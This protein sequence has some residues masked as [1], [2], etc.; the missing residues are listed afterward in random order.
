M[1]KEA[2]RQYREHSIYTVIQEVLRLT[3]FGLYS[4][5]LWIFD[6][7]TYSVG[8]WQAA[9][10]SV[11]KKLRGNTIVSKPYGSPSTVWF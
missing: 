1:F 3:C 6:L 8:L 7:N 5:C 9:A 2:R 11:L 4:L 10:Y